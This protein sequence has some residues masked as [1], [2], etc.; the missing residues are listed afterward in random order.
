MS[1]LMSSQRNENILKTVI[2]VA[3]QDKSVIMKGV[4]W[5]HWLDLQ[6]APDSQSGQRRASQSS[7]QVIVGSSCGETLCMEPLVGPN[8]F[9]WKHCFSAEGF[10]QLIFLLMWTFPDQSSLLILFMCSE[11]DTTILVN[12]W[13]PCR[14]LRTAA[15][16]SVLLCGY[17]TTA[18]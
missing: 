2:E 9:L 8:G 3:S 4:T 18:I 17:K 10:P 5:N 13:C 15:G 7:V 12:K 14:G 1:L 11:S 6:L 16:P